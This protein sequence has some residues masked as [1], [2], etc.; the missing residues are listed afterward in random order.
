LS[1]F[2]PKHPRERLIVALDVPRA[3]EALR[4]AEELSGEVGLFKVGLELFC[5]EGPDLVKALSRH[6]RIFLDLKF[7]D[8]PNT[9]TGALRSVLPL[10]P[11]FLTVHAT[12]GMPM[13]K[14]VSELLQ[15]HRQQGGQTRSLAVT[16]LTSFDETE[17]K[18][19]GQTHDTAASVLNLAR[20][21]QQ[22]GMDGGVCS[23]QEARQLRQHL[24]TSFHLVCPGIRPIGS[25][26]GDQVRVSDPASA[27][28]AGADYLVVGRPI[29]ASTHPR[30]A[31]HALVESIQ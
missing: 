11:Y 6:A 3:S 25:D 16:V 20:L 4:L 27:L 22:S 13:M 9:V 12:G 17:W 29:T 19:V 5:A 7:L 24:G 23:P 15:T 1:S 18:N 2:R 28:Q 14:A 8:I 21:A 26:L 30:E 31:A 10:D